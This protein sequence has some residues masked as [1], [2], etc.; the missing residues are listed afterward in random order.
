MKRTLI[1]VAVLTGL[2]LVAVGYRD[3]AFRTTIGTE[4]PAFTVTEGDSAISLADYRG[5]Y[6]LVNFWRSTDAR[7]RRDINRYVAWKRSTGNPLQILSINL[8]NNPVLY[9]E[10]VR[11]D[12]LMPEL[13][14]R[15]E[16][17]ERKQIMDAYGLGKGSGSLLIDP[18]GRIV[19]HNP[20]PDVLARL[21][22]R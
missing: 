2:I 1:I 10:I 18:N 4:A 11:N 13:Q 19:S 15:P 9:N 16:G 5:K 22:R 21:T 17:I 7:S 6:V 3:D 8:D 14:H 20:S 12:S